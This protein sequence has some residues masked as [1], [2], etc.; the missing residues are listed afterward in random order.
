LALGRYLVR[1]LGLEDSTDTLGRWMAHHLAELMGRAQR[2]RTTAERRTA[3]RDAV[4][5][6]L[7]IWQHR[8]KLPSGAYPLAP[9]KDLLIALNAL[10]PSDNPFGA[11][12][13]SLLTRQEPLGAALF[14]RI[15]RLVIAMLLRRAPSLYGRPKRSH[16][17]A[18]AMMDK[19]EKAVIERLVAWNDLF[20]PAPHERVAARKTAKRTPPSEAAFKR[21][22]LRLID[23]VAAVLAEL[24]IATEQLQSKRAAAGSAGSRT[25]G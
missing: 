3:Q 18:L 16:D 23:D 2:A 11:V 14:D 20:I 10:R 1:E 7:R 5:V 25:K 12:G 15:A 4:D 24:R 21:L 22:T 6:I 8:A 19:S 13:R 17:V 9:Y